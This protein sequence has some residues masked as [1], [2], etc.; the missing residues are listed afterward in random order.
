MDD[1]LQ[2]LTDAL[3]AGPKKFNAHYSKFIRALRLTLPVIALLLV[4]IVF[5]ASQSQDFTPTPRDEVLSEPQGQ[6]ELLNPR[7][8]SADKDKQPFTITAKKATQD[9]ADPDLVYLEKPVSDMTSKDG[10]WIAIEADKG[11]YKQEARTLK[12]M[13]GMRLFH[14]QGYEMVA[15]EADIDMLKQTAITK[16][17]VEGRGPMGT[18]KAQKLRAD[19][20]TGTMIFEG[21]AKLVLYES[22][23]K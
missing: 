7:F 9:Q 16:G 12:L 20:T 15:D 19:G 22:I 5:W 3:E 21:P 18:I 14:D 17:A 2:N 6:T 8:E 11:L 4:A 13:G 1:R 23:L 10:H